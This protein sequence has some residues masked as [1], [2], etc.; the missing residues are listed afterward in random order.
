VCRHTGCSTEIR[1]VELTGRDRVAC[2]DRDPADE[3]TTGGTVRLVTTP[4]GLRAVVLED[5]YLNQAIANRERLYVFH[6]KTCIRN[7]PHN[8]MPEH[9]RAH[10]AAPGPHLT[11]E[12]P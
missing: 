1:F 11:E 9:L 12:T 2:L 4:A 10:P 3:I 7:R 5:K 8:P 6:A